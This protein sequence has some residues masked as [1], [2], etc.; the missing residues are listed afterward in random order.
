M[1]KENISFPHI[2]ISS[3]SEKSF[4]FAVKPRMRGQR[5]T[6]NAMLHM[7]WK[8]QCF[9]KTDSHRKEESLKAGMISS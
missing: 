7:N 2:V 5:I 4:P 1:R 6:G 9:M 3:E 8:L